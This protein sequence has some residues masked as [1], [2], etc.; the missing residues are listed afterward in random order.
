[1]RLRKKS[2]RYTNR[3]L[4]HSFTEYNSLNS[5]MK[6]IYYVNQKNSDFVE[7]SLIVR[8]ILNLF[9]QKEKFKEAEEFFTRDILRI[10]SR[11]LFEKL[12]SVLYELKNEHFRNI[13]N[14]RILQNFLYNLLLSEFG[15]EKRFDKKLNTAGLYLREFLDIRYLNKFKT[16]NDK[17]WLDGHKALMD[18]TIASL[19]KLCKFIISTV[20]LDYN[21]KKM[22]LKSQLSELNKS[23][24]HY[25]TLNKYDFSDSNNLGEFN[26]FKM[27]IIETRKLSLQKHKLNLLFLILYNIEN[28]QLPKDFFEIALKLYKSGNL[29][30]DLNKAQN[31]SSF[32]DLDWLNYDGFEGG[33]QAILRFNYDKYILLIFFYNYLEGGKK[34]TGIQNL[35]K[36]HFTGTISNLE[37]EVKKFDMC[38]VEKYFNFNKKD[39]NKFK[40]DSLKNIKDKKKE[41]KKLES[42]YIIESKI[43]NEYVE[44]FKNDCI[45]RWDE[46]QRVLSKIFDIEK[47][48]K[49]NDKKLFFGQ[50]TLLPKEWFLDSFDSNVKLARTTG[51]DFGRD[52]AES[53]Y[54]KILEEINS[55]FDKEKGD[56]EIKINDLYA[57]LSKNMELDKVYYLFYTGKE[58]YSLPNIEWLRKDIFV[59]KLKIK[60][61]E[62]YFCYSRIPDVL[63]F[64][65]RAFTLKQYLDKEKKELT[66]DINE[67]FTDDEIKKI[68]ESNKSLKT[69]KDVLKN[70]KMKVLEKFEIER[71]NDYKLIRLKFKDD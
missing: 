48:K 42:K 56:K 13:N 33:V 22:Y 23:L 6:N 20:N 57:D 53:K 18:N 16:S 50:H 64:E 19:F 1:M 44:Q 59:A 28:S 58:I 61:S 21:T 69:K 29:A 10:E 62:F 34:E 5:L 11:N 45:N 40:K 47:V 71:N 51:G 39:F 31:I 30:S 35:T 15:K 7:E 54:R 36:E 52:Q 38:F 46:M 65:K 24:G 8:D 3:L 63:L 49:E 55:K 17:E 14:V 2:K 27:E 60:N 41:V 67:N 4:G 68:L 66:I 37:E 26:N 12:I 25:E 32:I 70:V 43:K 9:I